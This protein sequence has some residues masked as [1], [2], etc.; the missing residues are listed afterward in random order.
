[1]S[2]TVYVAD[3]ERYHFFAVALRVEE[4]LVMQRKKVAVTLAPGVPAIVGSLTGL[5]NGFR[6]SVSAIIFAVDYGSEVS[7]SIKKNNPA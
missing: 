3:R 4:G 7:T 5:C 1:M 2:I 6:V